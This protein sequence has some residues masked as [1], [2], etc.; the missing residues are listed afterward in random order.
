MLR[1]LFART[2][3]ACRPRRHTLRT[4]RLE[5]RD[6]LSISSIAST[7]STRFFIDTTQGDVATCNYASFRITNDATPDAD[8]WVKIDNFTGGVV[9]NAPGADG[10]YHVGP[11]GANASGAAFFYLQALTSTNTAQ[12]YRISVYEADPTIGAPAAVLQ[13]NFTFVDVLETL[14]ASDTKVFTTSYAP[15]TAVLGGKVTVTV[16]GQLGQVTGADEAAFTPACYASWLCDVYE[17]E[18][19]TISITSGANTQTRTNTLLF[20]GLVQDS[21]GNPYTAVY[22][23]RVVGMTASSVPTSPTQFVGKNANFKHHN[24]DETPIV[25]LPPTVNATTLAKVATP[26]ILPATGGTV[27][28]TLRLT[29]TSALPVTVDQLIDTLPIVPAA[30]TYKPGTSKFNGVPIGEPII[31]ANM[32]TWSGLFTVPGNS[33]ID[34]TFQG[35]LPAVVGSYTDSAIGRIGS[36]QIDTTLNTTDNAPATA[37]VEVSGLADL[38]IVKTDGTTTY[39]PGVPQTYTLT[40]T[41]VGPNAVAGARVQDVIPPPATGATWT[42]VFTNGSGTASGSGSI[43]Q[44]INLG[45]GGTAVY[46]VIMTIPSTA[47]AVLTNTATVAVPPNRTDPNPTNNSSTDVNTAA[48]RADLA[49]TKN[50]SSPTYIPGGTTSYTVVVT[51]NG[52]SFVTGATVV[53]TFSPLITGATW[54]A[55]FAGAGS[56]GTLGG[57]GNI[58]Q[59]INLAAGG[60]ATYTIVATVSPTAVTSLVNTATVAPP[61]GTIDPIPANNTA[62][63][64]DTATP[65]CDLAIVKTDGVPT[66]VPGRTTFYTVTV[67]NSGPSFLVGGR[68]T[69]V[70]PASITGATWVAV[71][72][73]SGSGGAAAGTGNIN[74]LIDLAPAGTATFTITAPVNSNATGN[75]INTATVT[76]P[77]GTT[78][79]TPGNNSST[80]TDTPAPIADL[81]IL[82]TDGTSQYVP[83]GTTTYTVTVSNVGPSDVLGAQV[84]DTLSPLI[85][86]AAWTAVF[87]N[88]SGA[89]SGSGSINQSITLRAGGQAVYT[90]VASILSSATGNLVNTATIAVPV[91]TTDPNLTNNSATDIDT[92]DPSVDLGIVKTDGTPT[93]TPGTTTTYTITVT[94]TGSSDV[95][96]ARVQDTFPAQISS[97]TWNAVFTSGTGTASGSG[98]INQ[99]INLQAGGKAVYTVVA[100]ILS[101]ATGN[102][103]NTA[104]ITPPAGVIDPNPDNQTSTD[105]DLPTPRA[106]LAITKNDGSPTFVP[107]G[108]TT[109]TVVVTNNGPSFVTGATVVDTFSPLIT[110]ATWTAVFAGAGSG[111]TLGGSGNI[112]QTINLAAGGTATYTIV[113]TVS[114]T[115]VTSLVNTATVAP[116]IGTIDPIPANNTATDTDTATPICDLAI[117]K[118]DGVPT[119]VPGRTTFYTVTVTNSGPS[120]LV[121]G[122]VTDVFPASITGA[123]WVAVYTGSGSGGTAA[124]SGNINALIDLAPTGVA[125]FTITAP[126]NSNAT[127]NLINTATITVPAGTTDPTPG[128]NSSTDTDTPAPIADLAILKTDG[129][130]TYLAGQPTVYTITVT[131]IGP[132]DVLGA[133][134]VDTLSPLVGSATWTAVFTNGT[135]TTSGSGNI[136]QLIN[137]Q[138]GGTAVYTVTANVL[139]SATGNLVNTATIAVPA[140]TSDPNP[141][142]NSATDVNV[143]LPPGNALVTG[144]DDGCP[145]APLVRVLDP[146]AGQLLAQFVAY[147]PTFRGGVR[148]ATGDLNGD[149]LDEIVTAPGRGRPGEIRVWT[150]AGVELPAYR[151]FPFGSGYTGGVEVTLGDVTKDG[152]LDIVAGMSNGAGVV[153]VFQVLPFA[154][155]PVVNVPYRSFVPFPGPYTGGVNVAAADFGTFVNGVKTSPAQDGR[156]EVVV[157]TNAGIAATVRI[158]D[159]SVTPKI[160]GTI[161]P[162][163]PTFTGGVTLSIGRWDADA[164]PDILVGAGINGLSVVEVYS[165]STFA[166]AARLSAFS[167]FAKPNAKVYATSLDTTGDGIID[168]VYAVQGQQ[169]IAGTKGVSVWN[170]LGNVTSQLPLTASFVPPL[171][172]TNLTKRSPLTVRSLRA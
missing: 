108:T 32:L 22:T 135:G 164:I 80:D 55:V 106:D 162:I 169:G 99:L 16:T 132:S 30:E 83:G 131:N 115:A 113:A 53:D 109:Y 128:N 105:I 123:T 78:D 69:D 94:N 148:V 84:I 76:V 47:T 64:T 77:A 167:G 124:G 36:T 28:F 73:G 143:P 122:R 158:Y 8:I 126:V 3:R 86:S 149:G 96:G 147:E 81:A 24:F 41:N 138:I 157:G 43:D 18:Q 102:L 93:Y 79:P 100:G 12:G 1:S 159:L 104:T 61:I 88:G 25:P 40:V 14:T 58:N 39:T 68:V 42:A 51:N 144:T 66:Y 9:G 67:T 163:A 117:V 56:G 5:D 48:P 19:T 72:T 98:N 45:V 110:G 21:G 62:T 103:V 91:G 44:L 97:V 154:S 118:T 107:G 112:N 151:T 71:Y 38:A 7:S 125:T 89:P 121:G 11:L 160:V 171:R 120:F 49:I 27:D 165:G 116:P 155:D 168:R 33:S 134:V 29:N 35:L 145:S 161:R 13:R 153:S 87:T 130:A 17:L 127:G 92:I 85:G 37:T 2:R 139:I 137:L 6:M 23:F 170:R 54:T 119:Y 46:T 34:L 150:Q 75:L 142:N 95:I 133:R 59:T 111:G 70:F 156:S 74:A 60:T 31:V 166:Q 50:D 136:N 141:T 52:P 26:T 146:A 57:S 82:K 140:G 4:E 101:T 10:I 129:S 65:I 20:N 152:Q 90:I 172:I 15:A 63:D 114:P